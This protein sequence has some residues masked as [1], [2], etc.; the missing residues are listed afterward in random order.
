MSVV[1]NSVDINF[2]LARVQL[3]LLSPKRCWD[4]IAAEQTP[5]IQLIKKLILPLA[6]IGAIATCV[7]LQV[8]GFSVPFYGRWSPPFIASLIHQT[9]TV[10]TLVACLYG[11]AWV[12]NKLAPQFRTNISFE[13][14]FSL[15]AHASIPVIVGSLLGINPMLE[16]A[17][18]GLFSLYSLLVLF[19]GMEKMVEIDPARRVGFFVVAL[20]ALAI[21]HIL[22]SSVTLPFTPTPLSNLTL[23]NG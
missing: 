8:F 10:L 4:T 23:G 13:R 7:G 6:C 18:G 14:G 19:Y 1:T 2:I 12:L 9:L 22:A 5:P 3:V 11:D 20:T 16:L 15:V 21:V 17:L